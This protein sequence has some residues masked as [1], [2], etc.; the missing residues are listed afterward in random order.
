MKILITGSASGIGYSLGCSLLKRGHFVYFTVHRK[1]Q[2]SSLNERLK[3]EN[4]SSSSYASFSFDITSSIE[5]ESVLSLPIDC[6]ICNA[7]EGVGGS[8]FDLDF[9]VIRHV[10]EVNVFAHLELVRNYIEKC[11]SQDCFGKVIVM[12]SMAGVM[13]VPWMDAYCASKAA[14]IS[15]L[16]NLQ[17][18]CLGLSLP[19][20]IKIIEPGIYE[21]GFNEF[22]LSTVPKN[23]Y[24]SKKKWVRWEQTFFHLVSKKTNKSIVKKILQALDSSS[25]RLIYR[26]PFSQRILLK[27]YLLFFG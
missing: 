1:E 15:F 12:A 2:L 17:R 4:F 26:A 10:F 16:T 8:L 9:A 18:E 23:S 13:P 3:K 25:F 11:V 20:S 24:F 19:C 14:L 27:I 6:L 5:R 21:T 7:A 22:M